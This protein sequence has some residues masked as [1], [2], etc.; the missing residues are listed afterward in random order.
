MEYEAVSEKVEIPMAEE[1]EV[2]VLS[3]AESIKVTADDIEMVD[4]RDELDIEASELDLIKHP[5]VQKTKE[6]FG[7]DESLITVFQK[8]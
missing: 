8:V 7:I 2:S 4:G 3:T 5:L 6:V 1:P